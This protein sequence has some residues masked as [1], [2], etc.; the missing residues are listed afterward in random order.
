MNKRNLTLAAAGL[1][2]GAIGLYAAFSGSAP[3]SDY[4]TVSSPGSGSGIL[5]VGKVR[6]SE[7]AE[8]VAEVSGRILSSPFEEGNAVKTG[9]ILFLIDS[10]DQKQIVAQKK[11]AYES[12]AAQFENLISS[13]LP[14]ARQDMLQAEKEKNAAKDAFSDAITL[15]EAGALS[16]KSL[17]DVKLAYEASSVDYDAAVRQYQS[18]AA[19]GSVRKQQ[20]AALQSAKAELDN[21]VNQD[22]KYTVTSPQDGVLLSKNAETGSFV[23]AGQSLAHVANLSDMYISADLDEQYFSYVST[24]MKAHAF[25]EE[26]MKFDAIVSSVS[27]LIDAETGSFS[28]KLSLDA[29]F[30]YKASDLTINIEILPDAGKSYYTIPQSYIFEEDDTRYVWKYEAGILSKTKVLPG[31]SHPGRATVESGLSAGDILVDPKPEFKDGD[32]ISLNL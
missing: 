14:G 13:Q 4:I 18:L 19:D 5:A 30:P 16:Q 23:Q 2:L 28:V 10:A 26:G 29:S 31:P 27:P 25:I 6:S 17:D 32:K 12:S 8:L 1:I 15:Y 9:D 3:E 21:A 22:S 11:A 7:S 24:G 20:Q